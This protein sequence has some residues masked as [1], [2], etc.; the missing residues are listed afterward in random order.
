M[1]RLFTV[2]CKLNQISYSDRQW[3]E[4]ESQSFCTYNQACPFCGGKG[5]LSE[6]A[7]YERYLIGLQED[8]PT[9]HT[10]RIPRC[11]CESCGHTHALLSSC[12]VPSRSYSLRFILCVL[13]RYFLG[14]LTVEKLC[15]YYEISP[16]TL[17]S[18]KDLFH[19]HKRLWLGVLEDM[20]LESGDFLNQL[21]GTILQR[22]QETFLFSL[23][24]LDNVT[25][26][27]VPYRDKDNPPAVT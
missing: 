17:Y 21:S 18:W 25:V 24:E 19:K 27:G 11:H 1:I 5:H 26:K 12:L 7:H 22:F 3:F 2:L 13:R 8:R 20:V 10:L 14:T 23:L 16:S 6:F 4:R 9:V 15:A